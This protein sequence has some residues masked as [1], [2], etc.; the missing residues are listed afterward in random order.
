MPV[1]AAYDLRD[2]QSSAK[3]SQDDLMC[4][5]DVSAD[6]DEPFL[7]SILINFPST[8]LHYIYM[9]KQC[10]A[11]HMPIRSVMPLLIKN[12]PWFDPSILNGNSPP[13]KQ[14]QMQSPERVA[15]DMMDWYV[16]TRIS[17]KVSLTVP[18]ISQEHPN[19]LRNTTR[20]RNVSLLRVSLFV[21][22]PVEKQ[23]VSIFWK[24][25]LI[26]GGPS[27]GGGGC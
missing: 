4:T 7:L 5:W 21:E 19:T 16:R 8:I 13:S 1:N 12:L 14:V 2:S 20:K 25:R 26:C 6:S 18:C 24:A 22:H 15:Q 10:L 23:K 11:P 3:L 9:V 17:L 27:P